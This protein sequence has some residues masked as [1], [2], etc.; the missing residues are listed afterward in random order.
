MIDVQGASN[1]VAS[2]YAYMS[3]V[4]AIYNGRVDLVDTIL[5]KSG[6]SINSQGD[7]GNTLLMFAGL[8]G[9]YDAAQYLLQN[10]ADYT[11]TNKKGETALSLASKAGK[12]DIVTL[13]R[14]FGAKS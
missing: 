2:N 5:V 12:R 8:W 3:A 13:L 9:Q 4:K 6:M 7:T 14:Q 1:V 11:L 10:K